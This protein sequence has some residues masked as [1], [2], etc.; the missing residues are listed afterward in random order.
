MN[1][2]IRYAIVFSFL[3]VS[4]AGI[5]HGQKESDKLRKQ[6]QELK[7]RISNTKKLLGDTRNNQRITVAE[8]GII[9]QQIAYRE[10]LIS[11]YER[12]VRS[13]NLKIEENKSVI[14]SLREDKKRLLAQYQS[15]IAAAYKNRNKNNPLFFVFSAN[16]FNQAYLRVKY[17]Q[18]ITAYR[19]RQVEM[20]QITVN[21]LQRK[22][23]QL[24][25]QIEQKKSLAN[26]TSKERQ[27]YDHDKRKQQNMLS[28][29]RKQEDK[30]RKQLQDQEEK[31]RQLDVAIRKAIEKEIA[32]AA[33]KNNTYEATPEAKL[34][35]K[36]FEANKGRL[37]WP[38]ER[39][40]ITGRYGNVPHPVVK[41]VIINNNGI[42]ITTTAGA[43][44][45]A[46]FEGTVSSILVIPGAGKAVMISHGTYRTVY[47]NMKEV[48]VNKGDQ[49]TTKQIL[50]TLLPAEIANN[51]VCHFEIWKISG[52]KSSS[53]NPEGWIYR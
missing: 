24:V 42:D 35:A 31:K 32:A 15:M 27:T 14:E 2:L 50:G 18:K 26:E 22:E 34:A 30:L 13:L 16:S 38:V 51:S 17:M 46:I 10:E 12:Q 48:Y 3:I 11:T 44:A 6:Q 33:K 53:Q 7:E 47:A 19:K 8:L 9:N 39:G 25:E 5:S 43:S 29:L 20:I 4:G 49:V 37:P 28:E 45:R 36:N 41:G 23:Q 1:G 21:E 52:S 40:E